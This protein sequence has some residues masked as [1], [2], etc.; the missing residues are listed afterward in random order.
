MVL[1]TCL[2]TFLRIT[3]K[4]STTEKFPHSHLSP[5]VFNGLSVDRNNSSV[6]LH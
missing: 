3:S 6:N 5:D 4:W 1:V 2:S